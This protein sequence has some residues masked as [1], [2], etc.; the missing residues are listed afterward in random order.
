MTGIHMTVV[1][2][3]IKYSTYACICLWQ[4][5][6]RLLNLKFPFCVCLH[7][8]E[9]TCIKWYKLIPFQQQQLAH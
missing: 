9:N 4:N 2:E 5:L 1:E 7:K 3:K 8:F 6:A